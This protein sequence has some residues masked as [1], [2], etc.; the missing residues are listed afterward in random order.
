MP[1]LPLPLA[2]WLRSTCGPFAARH[3]IQANGRSS[4]WRI[5]AADADLVV[6]TYAEEA[7]WRAETQAYHAWT[8]ALAPYAPRLIADSPEHR[9]L[10]LEAMPG[11]PMKTLRAG[12]AELSE[13]GARRIYE[14]TG[15]A[16]RRFRDAAVGPRFDASTDAVSFMAAELHR[17]SEP[18]LAGHGL[19]ARARES[20][21]WA[22]RNLD[23][24]A[25]LPAVPV[26]TDYDT[27]N[28]LVH[29]DTLTAII[30]FEYARWGVEDETFLPLWTRGYA[31][32]CAGCEEAFFAGYGTRFDE[33]AR[34]RKRFLLIKQALVGLVYAVRGGDARSIAERRAELGTL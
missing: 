11:V 16:A 20:V 13:R 5:A 17:W 10:V 14:Q 12:T 32:L 19:D 3:E 34:S 24:F 15:A 30:D 8:A 4:V 21:M 9:C 7:P 23:A 1:M 22:E 31:R 29:D 18:A 25:G 28:W 33:A 2:D 6:K 27:G 26:N